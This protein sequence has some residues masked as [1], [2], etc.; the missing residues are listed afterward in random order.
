MSALP[1]DGVHDAVSLARLLL[2]PE[3]A[4]LLIDE[5]RRVLDAWRRLP[6][7]PDSWG[8]PTHPVGL[9]DVLRA[10]EPEPGLSPAEALASA[11]DAVDGAFRV[12]RVSDIR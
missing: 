5:C 9:H 8:G 10:D 6:E 2:E 1:G 3:D 12:P 7:R 4:A 11:P